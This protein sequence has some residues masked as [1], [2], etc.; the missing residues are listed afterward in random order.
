MKKLSVLHPFLF[1]MFPILFL[2]AYNMH[3][4]YAHD[5]IVPVIAITISTL[6]LFL[7]TKKVAKSYKKSGIITTE[8]LVL[9]FSYG[10]ARDL[11]YSW[12]RFGTVST[13]IFLASFCVLSFLSG[14]F[15]VLKSR[16]DF[17]IP[18]KFLNVTATT[19]V[20]ISL[21]NIGIGEIRTIIVTT[22]RDRADEM[23]SLEDH[24][25]IYYIILDMY[26][27]NSTYEI[28]GYDNSEFTDYLASKGFY[29]ASESR[30]NY[31]WTRHSM[32]SS[33]NMEYLEEELDI[34]E[35]N[36]RL[37]NNK[38]SQF[39][40][41]KGYHYIYIGLP[42]WADGFRKYAEVWGSDR[43]V[44][45]SNFSS[46]L[47]RSSALAPFLNFQLSFRP[48]AIEI[49][50]SL[51]ALTTI[52]DRK[53][54]IFVYAHIFCPRN[55]FIF[56]R[57]GNIVIPPDDVITV[58]GS[59]DVTARY[60]E[61]VIFITAKARALVDGLLDKNPNAI[62]ILQ[63]DHGTKWKEGLDFDILNAYYL[64]GVSNDLL[65]ESISPVNTFR[66]VFNMYFGT[67]YKL[68][69]DKCFRRDCTEITDF[70]RKG[71][72]SE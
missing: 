61:Q 29:V 4:V 15:L 1:A 22:E 52:P 64:P 66:V 23:V 18:T 19:L 31:S 32:A 45:I 40:K 9:F 13:N 69:E 6:I 60:I 11:I 28:Y 14:T 44:L 37:H 2:Y 59:E 24:P 36:K 54:P 46:Y 50:N 56:D 39:L 30:S 21:L 20:V 47:V 43:P 65:Y 34:A 57:Y 63:A 67:E 5:L 53:E 41:S 16:K 71:W 25:D 17:Q 3:E 51:S 10:Y 72:L 58:K 38:V 12:E 35:L 48:R 68:L 55:P 33:L 70:S 49:Q 62:I 27:R 7:L 8:F 26:A 42:H